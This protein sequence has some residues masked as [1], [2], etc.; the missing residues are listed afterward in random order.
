MTPGYSRN[1]AQDWLITKNP[2]KFAL[3]LEGKNTHF[4]ETSGLNQ[5]ERVPRRF[6]YIL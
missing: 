5:K 2:S 6:Y 1:L 4:I 3:I